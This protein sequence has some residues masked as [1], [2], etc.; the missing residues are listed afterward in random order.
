LTPRNDPAP[1]FEHFRA[2]FAS[3]LLIAAV[4]HFQ[5]FEKLEGRAL[6]PAELAAAL[7]LA[8]RPAIVLLSAIRAMGLVIADAEGKLSLSPV[9]M[10]QL[11]AGSYFS[12]AGYIALAAESPAVLELVERL[13]A[14]RTGA[15]FIYKEG[16]ES[17][18]E[19]EES[20]R[21]LTLALAGRAKNVAPVL[22]DRLPL[23]DGILL[24]VG[25]GTGIYSIAFLQRNPG[26]KAIILD[27]P[28]VLRVARE[29]A[30]REGVA[31]RVELRP[32]DMFSAQFPQADFVLLS[33]ILHDWDVGDCRALVRRA[34]ECLLPGGSVLI[35]DVLL[36]DA[37]DGPLAVACY[38]AQLFTLTEGRAYSAAEFQTW[39]REAGLDVQPPIPT[40]ADCH[41]IRGGSAR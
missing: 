8:D 35:H 41:L 27:R 12:I 18:M 22:A 5:L 2:S 36:N 37:L 20:A 9:A 28:E 30:E 29:F 1:I 38:S 21:K 14:N 19:E 4:A 16:I 6:S 32:S 7:G 13:R 24:D 33:N 23:G 25:G 11:T 31:D 34:A 10:E 15:S 39:L 26:L 17:T 40:L 3:N